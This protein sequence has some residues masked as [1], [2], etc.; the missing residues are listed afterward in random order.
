MDT[1]PPAGMEIARCLADQDQIIADLKSQLAAQEQRIF[2]SEGEIKRLNIGMVHMLGILDKTEAELERIRDIAI[3]CNFREN[4]LVWQ[5]T[6]H[7]GQSVP[8]IPHRG[9][10]RKGWGHPAVLLDT[11]DSS[12]TKEQIDATH[13]EGLGG[14]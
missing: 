10:P 12:Q 2:D 14:Q 8:D 6:P 5:D 13:Y 3:P 1:T 9:I 7:D 11:L 4:R